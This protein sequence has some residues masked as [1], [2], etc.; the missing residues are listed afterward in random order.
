MKSL[1]LITSAALISAAPALARQPQPQEAPVTQE[2]TSPEATGSEMAPAQESMSTAAAP[3]A[4]GDLLATAEAQGEFTTLTRALQASGMAD[5]LKGTDYVTLFA[6]TDAAFAALPAGT[7]DELMKPENKGKLKALLSN[8]LVPGY[9]NTAF[10]AQQDKAVIDTVGG[11]KM[12][13]GARDGAVSVSGAR[14]VTADLR[15]SNGL[16]LGIDKVLIPSDAQA[17]I[18]RKAPLGR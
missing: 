13:I 6:P 18:A 9:A 4:T 16:I 8:H 3:A 17:G 5:E 14:V 1:F 10:L 11:A 15:A 12:T 7:M 2:A